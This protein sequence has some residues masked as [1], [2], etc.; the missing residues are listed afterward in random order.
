MRPVCWEKFGRSLG[1]TLRSPPLLS[2]PKS[3]ATTHHTIVHHAP[4]QEKVRYKDTFEQLRGT[5]K[6]I[7]HLHMLL[8]QSRTRLQKDFE[9]WLALMSRLVGVVLVAW[10]ACLQHLFTI[11]EAMAVVVLF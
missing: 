1:G 4:P 6:E 9:Q 5:K 2:P 8:E 11:C 7:E 3:V 10:D